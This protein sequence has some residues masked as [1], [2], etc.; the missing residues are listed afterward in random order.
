MAVADRVSCYD[1]RRGSKA[2]APVRPFQNALVLF[3]PDFP[4]SL[5]AVRPFSPSLLSLSTHSRA[6][7]DPFPRQVLILCSC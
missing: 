4:G 7:I 6:P 1:S 5:L 2:R 3:L